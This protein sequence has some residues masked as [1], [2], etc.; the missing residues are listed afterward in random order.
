MDKTQTQ[1]VRRWRAHAG[2][3]LL[4]SFF[5]SGA[6]SSMC[7]AASAQSEPSD[8]E[9]LEV[10]AAKALAAKRTEDAL[11]AFRAL[12]LLR[13]DPRDACHVGRTAYLLGKMPEAFEHLVICTDHPSNSAKNGA[14]ERYLMN[15]R[16]VELAKVRSRI[17]VLRVL[18]NKAGAQVFVD[19]ELVGVAPLP[20]DV[21]L[22]PGAVHHI[23]AVLGAERAAGE[24][25]IA[26]GEQGIVNLT[27]AA[28]PAA[29]PPSAAAPLKSAEP[30]VP[31]VAPSGSPPWAMGLKISGAAVGI[32]SLGLGI[33]ALV[34]HQAE[35]EA[36]ASRAPSLSTK[37]CGRDQVFP[38][39][40]AEHYEALQDARSASWVYAFSLTAG[41]ATGAGLFAA[42]V[43]GEALTARERVQVIPT[44]GGVVI[45]GAF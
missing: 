3:R 15:E 37:G 25:T 26:A 39:R 27:L 41:V 16:V 36:M 35:L 38:L 44:V 12:Y 42:G 4:S 11:D 30:A 21:G 40:C 33:G 1:T 28:P 29:T 8:F 31:S 43:V 45:R 7:A 34:A 13:G 19:G 10:E 17:G 32:V 6:L 5:V 18:V 20:R 2:A 23:T 9:R 24:I 14:Q 22:E